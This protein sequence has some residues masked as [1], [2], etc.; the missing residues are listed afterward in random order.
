MS[1]KTFFVSVAFILSL[2]VPL[3]LI[4]LVV[5]FSATTCVIAT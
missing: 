4:T 2:A 3:L 1:A 5:L